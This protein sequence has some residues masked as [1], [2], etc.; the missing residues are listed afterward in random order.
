MAH[1]DAWL[2]IAHNIANVSLSFSHTQ[3]SLIFLSLFFFF[4]ET[5]KSGRER[6]EL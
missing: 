2:G 4:N 5:L 1:F 6:E 3:A